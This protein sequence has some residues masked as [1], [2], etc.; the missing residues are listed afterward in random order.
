MARTVRIEPSFF[1]VKAANTLT[2]PTR[3]LLIGLHA[4]CESNGE[5]P[6]SINSLSRK[7]RSFKA[8]QIAKSIKELRVTNFITV[9]GKNRFRVENFDPRKVV[10]Q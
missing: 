2:P 3:L 5:F 4:L 7:F 9:V 8:T 6:G 1:A 10:L